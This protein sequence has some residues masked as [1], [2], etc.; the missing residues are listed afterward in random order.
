MVVTR[1]Y[2]WERKLEEGLSSSLSTTMFDSEVGATQKLT[3]LGL[4]DI[5]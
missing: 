3:S 2:S 1:D 5:F 4:R